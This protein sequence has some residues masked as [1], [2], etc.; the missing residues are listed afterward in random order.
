[1]LFD[2]EFKNMKFRF[3]NLALAYKFFLNRVCDFKNFLASLNGWPLNDFYTT[4]FFLKIFLY[5]A[6]TD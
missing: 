5:L 2:R 1:M 3:L 4:T 6:V